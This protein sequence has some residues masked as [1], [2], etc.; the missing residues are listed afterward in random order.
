MQRNLTQFINSRRWTDDVYE[1]SERIVCNLYITITGMPS[2]GR[3]AATVQVQSSRPVYN[4][5]Y[6]SALFNYI[7]KEWGFDY[8]ASQPINF[9]EAAF[10]DNL[11]SLLAFY[12]YLIIGLDHDSFSEEGGTKFYEKANVIANNASQSSAPGW[13]AFEKSGKNRYSLCNNLLNNRFSSFRK[14]LYIYHRLGMD[15][16]SESAENAREKILEALE[17]FI[18]TNDQM[19]GTMVINSF[20][21]AKAP[22]L[23]NIFSEASLQMRQKAYNFLIKIDPTKSDRYQKLI[24]G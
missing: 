24:S 20:F 8:A 7:D 5:S 3:F 15:V 11:S 13:S 22:E 9:T 17:N 6:S 2:V 23:I 19:P 21:D 10:T 14:G 18:K 1:P 16:Y 4:T 12:A